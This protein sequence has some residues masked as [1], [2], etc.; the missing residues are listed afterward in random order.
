[1]KNKNRN[2]KLSKIFVFLFFSFFPIIFLKTSFAETPKDI[3]IEAKETGLVNVKAT[4]TKATTATKVDT[5]DTKKISEIE[6]TQVGSIEIKGKKEISLLEDMLDSALKENTN[7]NKENKTLNEKIK[8]L[9]SL[10]N[11]YMER[12]KQVVSGY[13]NSEKEKQGLITKHKTEL[14]ELNASIENL[15]QEIVKLEQTY[16]ENQIKIELDQNKNDLLGARQ[17]FNKAQIESEKLIKENERLKEETGKL[18]YN[19]GNILF[20]LQKYE[21]A[22]I[23]FKKANQYLLNDPEICYNIATIYDYYLKDPTQAAKFYEKYMQLLP[24]AKDID[25]VKERLTEKRLKIK[26]DNDKVPHGDDIEKEGNV[27]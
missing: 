26:F 8:G 13:G 22:L 18:H 20:E 2:K 10:N 5:V 14:D 16:N 6:A 19:I 1:M 15:K 24:N 7:L 4:D 12:I 3:I 17:N 9:E 21:L 11:L 23:E 25:Y 27:K